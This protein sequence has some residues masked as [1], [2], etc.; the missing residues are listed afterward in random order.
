M[1]GLP[2]DHQNRALVKSIIDIADAFGLETVAEWVR[3]EETANI[4][5]AAGIKYLQGYL[6]GMPISVSELT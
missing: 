3:D 5:R 4:L 2:R 6:H 1:S